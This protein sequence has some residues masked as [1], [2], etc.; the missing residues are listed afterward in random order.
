MCHLHAIIVKLPIA[1]VLEE[2]RL[3]VRVLEGGIDVIAHAS[4]DGHVTRIVQF[5][6]AGGIIDAP[7]LFATGQIGAIV[8]SP[9]KGS[10]H[11][12]QRSRQ[13]QASQGPRVAGQQRADLFED[14][15]LTTWVVEERT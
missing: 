14:I 11:M 2:V 5:R 6:H 3:A 12:R 8:V 15:I 1:I 10:I 4:P 9:H 13:S 7:I